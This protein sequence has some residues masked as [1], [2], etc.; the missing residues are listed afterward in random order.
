MPPTWGYE[1]G[2]GGDADTQL[3]EM[4]TP[5]ATV[6]RG[7]GR[8]GRGR[9]SAGAEKREGA[10]LDADEG[11]LRRGDAGRL[12]GEGHCRLGSANR[13]GRGRSK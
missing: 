4:V 9:T 11:K 5:D 8:R 3:R 12:R 1:R 10:T 7:R 2:R 13:D 6:G